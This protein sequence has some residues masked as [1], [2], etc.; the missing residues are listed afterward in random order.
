MDG[1]EQIE[2]GRKFHYEYRKQ[3]TEGNFFSKSAYQALTGEKVKVRPGEY[4]AISNKE[5]SGTFYLQ[6]EAT[7][8]TNVNTG[9]EAAVTFMG[10]LHYNSLFTSDGNYVM[11]DEDYAAL[12]AGNTPDWQE[13]VVFF[14]VDEE[15]YEFA[16]AFYSAFVA[17]MNAK[18]EIVSGYDRIA[19]KQD[20]EAGETYWGDGEYGYISRKDYETPDFKR[21]WRFMPSIEIMDKNEVILTYGVFLMMFVFIVIVCLIAA[22]VIA[23]I[24]CLTVSINN[25]YVFDNLGRLGASP[26]FL[27]KEIRGQSSKIFLVPSVIG[28]S[29]MYLFMI[30]ILGMN[31]GYL[32]FSSSEV[33]GLLVCGLLLLTMAAVVTCVYRLTLRKM[34]RILS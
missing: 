33:N 18:S 32:R 5:E 10:Y 13:Q 20:M 2:E 15:S 28:M 16:K 8:L 24:R 11:S 6:S 12:A 27:K 25:R 17:S 7:L 3:L 29:T 19:R 31:D 34:Q 4:Y 30:L 22:M 1:Q 26:T 14:K 21:D 23:Y 9:K